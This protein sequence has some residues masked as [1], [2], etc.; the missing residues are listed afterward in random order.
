MDIKK[1]LVKKAQYS[2]AG[3]LPVLNQVEKHVPD[4]RTA[5]PEIRAVLDAMIEELD[6]RNIETALTFGNDAQA[7]RRAV[8]ERILEAYEASQF[9]FIRNPLEKTLE[10]IQEIDLEGISNQI[11]ELARTGTEVAGR[12]KLTVGVTFL[13]AVLAS[14]LALLPGAAVLGLSEKANKLRQGPKTLQEIEEHLRDKLIQFKPMVRELERVKTEIPAIRHNI[15]DLGRANL[16]A[17]QRTTLR[18]AAGE[19]AVRRFSATAQQMNDGGDESEAQALTMFVEN[20]TQKLEI[21][22]QT[23]TH[24]ILDITKLGDLVQATNDNELAL[25]SILSHEMESHL[26][27]M[28]A[29]AN[30]VETL[31]TSRLI[32]EFRKMTENSTRQAIQAADTARQVAASNRADN[33]ERLQALLDNLKETQ[34]ILTERLKALPEFEAAQKTLQGNINTAIGTLVDT[35]VESA[36]AQLKGAQRNTP[37][38]K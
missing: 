34:R 23:R 28:A 32:N 3:A 30:V 19:E 38:L 13:A 8:A 20:L 7:Q 14:P 35:Q 29:N 22:R 33:P 2:Q 26:A 27:S 25:E 37:A 18:L 1:F 15:T 36:K 12:N 31:R 5:T 10:A 21:H 17:L 24:G 11:S 16:D 9:A 4:Y 6:P